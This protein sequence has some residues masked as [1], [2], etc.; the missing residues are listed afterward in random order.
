MCTW[1]SLI[2]RLKLQGVDRLLFYFILF[3]FC[4]YLVKVEIWWGI[5]IFY[6]TEIGLMTKLQL[7]V[8]A[9]RLLLTLIPASMKVSSA[10]LVSSFIPS[11]G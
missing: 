4:N 10:Q 7:S 6:Y 3:K 5:L 1:D 2:L 8:M 9:R 11:A